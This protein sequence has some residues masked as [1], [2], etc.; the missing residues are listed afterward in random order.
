MPNN[1]SNLKNSN[2]KFNWGGL[3][4][5]IIILTMVGFGIWWFF[6]KSDTKRNISQFEDYLVRSSNTVS[7]DAYFKSIS[8]TESTQEIHAVYH[9]SNDKGDIS[10]TFGA[11]RDYINDM[12]TK[13]EVRVITGQVVRINTIWKTYDIDDM[14][15]S[16]NPIPQPSVVWDIIKWTLLLGIPILLCW[17]IWR[18]LRR[19]VSGGGGGGLFGPNPGRNK[20][21]II[22]SIKQRFSDIAG[23][24]EVK[25][26]IVELVDYLKNPDAYN[27][28]GARVPK[29]ILL[30]GPPGTGKTL[31]AKATAGE[32][33]V[34]FYF[35]SGSDFVEMFVGV[36]ASRVREMFIEA[37]RNAPCILFVDELDAVGRSRGGGIGGGNDEREQTLNQLLVEMDGIQENSSVLVI[38]ATNRPDVLDPALLRPGRFDR[39]IIVSLPDIK[40]REAILKVHATGKR[41]HSSISFANIAK[42]TPGYSGAQ[43]ENVI[44]EAAILSVREKTKVIIPEQ[45]DEAIDRVMAGPA[46]KSRVISKEELTTIA[47]HEAGHAVI[48]LKIKGG[49][50]VQKVTIIPRGQAGGYNLMTPEKEQ[51]NLAKWQILARITSFMGGRAAEQIMNGKDAISTGASNDIEQ[52]TLLAR[53][54]VTN[55]G[56]SKL[57]PVQ[58]EKSDGPLF[59]GRD[60]Q[61]SKTHSD[62]VAYEIDKE[63][64]DIIVNAEQNAIKVI[65]GNM[66]LLKVIA[67]TLLERETIVAEE[68]EYMAKHKK[69][70]PKFNKATT[71]V[72]KS[73]SIDDLINRVK[74]KVETKKKK[75]I[76]LEEKKQDDKEKIDS[77]SSDKND[78]EKL[79]SNSSNK[80]D[81]E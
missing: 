66:T 23:N 26:E 75:A 38:A 30:S 62:Q 22:K 52:A 36:G 32:A 13:K 41:M 68:I 6:I 44:N 59:L 16:G 29:G 73:Q 81:K 40:E 53:N 15:L 58:L 5:T 12:L 47:Y 20:A 48:G 4:V 35:I 71:N 9:Q 2:K 57:G 24:E 70:P 61:V 10:F 72:N 18:Q 34:P 28:A 49:Q 80:N 11:S 69:T 56:M 39:S 19:S 64:R 42:R 60:M 8:V 45:I 21:R 17:L 27:A 37:R 77:N 25:E 76:N 7:D 14:K 50:K 74:N 33:N 55:W 79:D 31:I 67:E 1:D 43:L 54:M 3:I 65:K 78:E 46:K 51:Y 63:V